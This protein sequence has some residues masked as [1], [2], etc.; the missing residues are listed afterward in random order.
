[1]RSSKRR[2]HAGIHAGLRR[3]P[4]SGS[5]FGHR[6]LI[7]ELR[8]LVLQLPVLGLVDR[9][10]ASGPEHRPLGFRAFELLGEL[11]DA[12][13]GVRGHRRL[14]GLALRSLGQDALTLLLGQACLGANLVELSL[15]RPCV[16]GVGS[17]DRVAFLFRA[18]GLRPGRLELVTEQLL[19]FRG[20]VELRLDRRGND[21]RR[22]LRSLLRLLLGDPH[23]IGGDAELGFHLRDPRLQLGDPRFGGSCLLL[24]LL[25]TSLELGRLDGVGGVRSSGLLL[26]L[27]DAGA[28]LLQLLLLRGQRG[29]RALQLL[30]AL[31]EAR[32]LGLGGARLLLVASS[33][34]DVA[35]AR[36][37][38]RDLFLPMGPHEGHDRHEQADEGHDRERHLHLLPRM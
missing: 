10:G 23:L 22:G 38:P 33:G 31:P 2:D 26:E 34:A 3:V 9:F 28:E 35:A 27:G 8:E 4:G 19:R 13:F 6:E 18:L 37:E 16:L 11:L 15:L 24:E 29:G 30:H 25:R 7:A 17:F 12:R 5:V 32:G 21:V 1:M 14:R 36:T 20:G